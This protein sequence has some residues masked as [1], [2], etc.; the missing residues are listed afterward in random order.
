MNSEG[1]IILFFYSRLGQHRANVTIVDTGDIAL[2]D[3]WPQT[4]GD[5]TDATIDGYGC[6]NV[7]PGSPRLAL[8][9]Y[10]NAQMDTEKY[11][12]LQ[13]NIYENALGH[14]KAQKDL[15]YDYETL[16][17]IERDVT[18]DLFSYFFFLFNRQCYLTCNI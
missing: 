1:V 14:K 6:I 8:K 5:L 4:E 3:V 2:W 7:W 12:W 18:V 16:E 9:T 15:S 11:S 17:R 10:S 13:K